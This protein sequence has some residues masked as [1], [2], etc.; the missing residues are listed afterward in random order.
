MVQPW[1][2]LQL[3]GLSLSSFSLNLNILTP[4]VNYPLF[5]ANN[6]PASK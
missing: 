2:K 4:T 3:G 6:L 5:K 1:K